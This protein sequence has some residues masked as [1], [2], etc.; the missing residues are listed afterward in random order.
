MMSSNGLQVLAEACKTCDERF[1]NQQT[2]NI[3]TEPQINLTQ[4]ILYCKA[5]GTPLDHQE[6]RA[7][8]NF[9]L[10]QEYEHGAELQCSHPICRQSGIKFRY[11]AFCK[12]AVAKRNFRKRHAHNDFTNDFKSLAH[13][14]TDK[15]SRY[16]E[17]DKERDEKPDIQQ[18]CIN[19]INNENHPEKI[20]RTQQCATRQP[21]KVV[22]L[23][24]NSQY[25][26]NH[27]QK[28]PDF[29][30]KLK[31]KIEVNSSYNSTSARENQENFDRNDI[32]DS[33]ECVKVLNG[34]TSLT[35]FSFNESKYDNNV[36]SKWIELFKRRPHSTTSDEK[37]INQ[38]ISE[39]LQ[40]A[41]LHSQC[42]K[43]SPVGNSSTTP[44]SFFEFGLL[45]DFNQLEEMSSSALNYYDKF[46][47]EV[48][49]EFKGVNPPRFDQTIGSYH[50]HT[51]NLSLSINTGLES[52]DSPTMLLDSQG[53]YST[54]SKS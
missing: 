38:W 16:N 39:V 22:S 35:T 2:M 6:E 11:C 20:R 43:I 47:T 34:G 45:H 13:T 27:Q 32:E 28:Q 48:K 4:P 52:I 31:D 10:G 44:K 8:L 5:R 29:T 30:E 24:S 33:N 40:V 54:M 3:V 42:N 1:A 50:Q 17:C 37:H 12:K 25:H 26:H 14:A 53:S 7:I 51:K 23:N 49:E 9:G 41:G 19:L 18:R 15:N 46:V 21:L 36:P